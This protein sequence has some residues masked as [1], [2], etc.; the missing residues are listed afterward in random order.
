M[1]KGAFR[2]NFPNLPGPPLK[3]KK[4]RGQETKNQNFTVLELK[5]PKVGLGNGAERFGSIGPNSEQ[6]KVGADE[7][8]GW[9]ELSCPLSYDY[10]KSSKVRK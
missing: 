6:Q 2:L 7:L 5:H 8:V 4:K 1:V 3:K 9:P 10:T